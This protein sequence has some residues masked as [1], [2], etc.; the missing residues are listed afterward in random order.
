MRLRFV[1]HDENVP[2]LD[3]LLE[4]PGVVEITY[5]VM[6][7]SLL[8]IYDPHHLKCENL[9]KGIKKRYKNFEIVTTKMAS[10]VD[11]D[12]NMLSQVFY[13]TISNANDRVRKGTG[14][15]IDL[16]SVVPVFFL[17]WGIE[18]LVRNPVMPKWYDILRS[19]ENL[20]H[21]FR[22]DYKSPRQ[23]LQ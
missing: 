5:N 10:K 2:D 8:V 6:T 23:V 4:I 9:I 13:E 1:H 16:T 11:L 18:E 14:G 20:F 3:G 12:K 17:L 21:Q 19:S 7:R 15:T 22:R